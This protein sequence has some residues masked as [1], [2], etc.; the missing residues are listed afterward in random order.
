MYEIPDKPVWIT[1]GLKEVLFIKSDIKYEL[2]NWI[3]QKYQTGYE[4]KREH[5]IE[6]I[7]DTFLDEDALTKVEPHANIAG[8]VGPRVAN[9]NEDEYVYGVD[10]E[11]IEKG[12]IL[13]FT[14]KC[15]QHG[16]ALL[17]RYK[18]P[19]QSYSDDREWV[20]KRIKKI[21]RL[22]PK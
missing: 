6:F 1:K 12:D 8:A 18:N 2:Q 10:D 16:C 21:D 5:L 14:G 13:S 15:A 20:Y 22:T 3:D 17:R 7:I 19:N 9:K 11:D 4:W